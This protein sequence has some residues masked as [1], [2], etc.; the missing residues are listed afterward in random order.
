YPQ[1]RG[2]GLRANGQKSRQTPGADGNSQRFGSFG[3]SLQDQGG[4]RRNFLS[5]FFRPRRRSDSTEIKG[6]F[7]L[8]W[9]RNPENGGFFHGHKA[10]PP[11]RSAAFPG[12]TRN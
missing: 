6:T 7:V 3:S 2:D 11:R 12:F 10:P 1:N 9:S 5:P 8:G 4:P